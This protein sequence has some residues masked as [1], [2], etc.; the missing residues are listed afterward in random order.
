MRKLF[1][2][3]VPIVFWGCTKN[4]QIQISGNISE[5]DNKYIVI[6]R[7]NINSKKVV[8]SVLINASGNFKFKLDA[9]EVDFYKLGLSENNFITL[10]VE[11]GEKIKL[12]SSSLNLPG[13]S[14]ISGSPGSTLLL[15][16]D[17]HL[18]KTISILDSIT[19]VYQAN[20]NTEGFDTLSMELNNFYDKA[21]NNQRR[22]SIAFILDHLSS[23]ASIKAIYQQYD[24]NTYVLND[25]KDIQ[26][27]KLVS[28]SL[29]VYYPDSKHTKALIANLENEMERVTQLRV[30]KLINEAEVQSLEISLP[31]PL[32]DTISL[33]SLKGKYVLLSFWASWDQ[34]SVTENLSF[35]PLYE[36]YKSSGFEIYQVSF[37]TNIEAWTRAIQFDELPWINVSDL[38]YPNSKVI[39]LFNIKGIPSN[40]FV[41]KKGTVIGSEMHGK[42]LKIKLEQVF[43]F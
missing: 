9:P 36:K 38:A 42:A 2:L 22:Y 10:L 4:V 40:Y 32:G 30:N 33:S 26:F 20:L 29:K 1:I 8:D 25:I 18:R 39:T 17:N 15:N 41:D 5:A 35:K 28:D 37:D 19:Q 31:D 13:N 34:A 3:L 24:D 12:T 11:P 23:L 16:I 14:T 43:G 21:L 6:E 27:M 7:V